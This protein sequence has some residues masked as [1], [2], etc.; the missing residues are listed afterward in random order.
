MLKRVLL[1]FLLPE[2]GKGVGKMSLF[3]F[4]PV[5]EDSVGPFVVL[6]V[7][8]P[9]LGRYHRLVPDILGL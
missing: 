5:R 9:E 7:C 6:D 8:S 1:I 3:F 4:K 2:N